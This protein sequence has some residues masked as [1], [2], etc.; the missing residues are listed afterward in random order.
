MAKII[1]GNLIL[2]KDEIIEEDLI[3]KGSIFG[4]CGGKFDLIV[5]GNLNCE[6]LNCRDLDCRDLNCWNLDCR[7]LNCWNLNCRDLDCLDLSCCDLKA[8]NIS[9]YAVCFAYKNIECET[10]KG[11]RENCKH[12]VLDGKIIINGKEQKQE[13]KE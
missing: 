10:I 5:K 11:R 9:Y 7:D 12:F 13:E 4:K 1:E 2:E 8:R 3:V 6:D